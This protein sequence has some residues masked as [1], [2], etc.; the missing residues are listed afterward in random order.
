MGAQAACDLYQ[1]AFC[2]ADVLV[3]LSSYPHL[4][5]F[6]VILLYFTFAV[7]LLCVVTAIVPLLVSLL[8][9][10]LTAVLTFVLLLWAIYISACS[11]AAC[12]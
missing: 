2:S 7:L 10:L 11:G 9:L 1:L 6:L 8:C 5:F 4:F 3:I 12:D